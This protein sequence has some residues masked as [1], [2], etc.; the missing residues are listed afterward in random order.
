MAMLG[1]A[2]CKLAALRIASRL[3]RCTHPSMSLQLRCG[4]CCRQ[5]GTGHVSLVI[6]T[7]KYWSLRVHSTQQA[8]KARPTRCTYAKICCRV[9]LF[10]DI[11]LTPVACKK[12]KWRQHWSVSS[13]LKRVGHR[14]QTS[15][16][17]C[18]YQPSAWLWS[19]VYLQWGYAWPMPGGCTERLH[20]WQRTR[21]KAPLT[22]VWIRM[23]PHW[24]GHD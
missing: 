14:T 13:P 17:S 11:P 12:D 9:F 24:I 23:G 16:L 2:R 7:R 19:C 10:Q 1:H 22:Y 3:V 8:C 15:F 21:H 5:Q 18:W 4:W 20:G 6:K